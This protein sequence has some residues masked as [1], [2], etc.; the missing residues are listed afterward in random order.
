MNMKWNLSLVFLAQM[1][2]LIIKTRLF[3]KNFNITKT[4]LVKIASQSIT[5]SVLFYLMIRK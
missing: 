4:L 5:G 3:T 2:G 1:D